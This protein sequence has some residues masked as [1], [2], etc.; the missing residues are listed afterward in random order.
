MLNVI[1]AGFPRT[2]T[3]S[4]KAALELLGLGPC[5]HMFDV[6]GTPALAERWAEAHASPG[7]GTDWEHLLQGWRSGV[8]WP[9]SFFWRELA[10]AYPE[11]RFVLT[12][13]DPHRWY[14]SMR[15]TIFRMAE[16]HGGAPFPESM[17]HMRAFAPLMDH[18]WHTHFG[19]AP[20]RTP[21]EATAVAAFERHNA[22][23]RAALPAD[24]LLV[25]RTGEGWDRLCAFLGA[26]VPGEPFPHLNDTAAMQSTQQEF[27]R[28]EI[29]EFPGARTA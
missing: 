14:T 20:G 17:A 13:R 3:T 4:M 22:E 19:G 1:G 2:G 9:V 23:V 21:D 8:D 11:A 24:R 16:E 27:A 10:E 12:V 5:H 18:M 6:L 15:E 29:P 26:D 7:P 25:Y 28:G